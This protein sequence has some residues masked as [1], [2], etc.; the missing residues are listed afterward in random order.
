[1]RARASTVHAKQSRLQ[2]WRLWLDQSLLDVLCPMAYTEDVGAFGDQIRA[3][4]EFAGDIPVWAGVGAYRLSSAATLAHTAAAR[5]LKT[6]GIVLFSYDSL[7]TPPNSATSLAEL[8]RAA[9]GS[10][11][12]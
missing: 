3:A 5:R 4:Q 6:A 1:L 12:R 11:S 8:G 2:D 9:F 10:G 7:I